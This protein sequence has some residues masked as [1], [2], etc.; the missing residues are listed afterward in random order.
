MI[1][2]VSY[3]IQVISPNIAIRKRSN[4]TAFL[5][6]KHRRKIGKIAIVLDHFSSSDL[7]LGLV[8]DG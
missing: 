5:L 3:I 6:W 7:K 4:P 1:P 8:D 2:A